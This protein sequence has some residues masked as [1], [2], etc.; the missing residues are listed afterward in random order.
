M[1]PSSRASSR[2]S[3]SSPRSYHSATRGSTRSAAQLRTVS[4]IAR[5]SGSS[6]SSSPRGS[7]GS[8][9]A[10]SRTGTYDSLRQVPK[11]STASH[12]ARATLRRA[13]PHVQY[14]PHSPAAA[15]RR[16]CGVLTGDA[17]RSIDGERAA[18]R[19]G[20]ATQ[21]E[22]RDSTTPRGDGS[23][24]SAGG[25]SHCM[26]R[27]NRNA[28]TAP[29]SNNPAL[30]SSVTCNPCTKLSLATRRSAPP[31]GPPSCPATS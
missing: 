24:T 29:T 23:S 11:T 31:T 18:R 1:A 30:T 4:R 25:D 5:S 19:A 13:V 17:R 2:I 26:T 7:A 28:I 9:G 20:G 12:D 6:R 15:S 10:T 16:R 27:G 8:K 3:G 21:A 22:T 14:A